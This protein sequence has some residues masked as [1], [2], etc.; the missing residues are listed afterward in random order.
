MSMTSSKDLAFIVSGG[1]T[2]TTYLGYVLGKFIPDAR[3]VHEP[4]LNDG[5]TLR[6]LNNLREFG[7]WHMVLGRYLK[8][9]GIRNLAQDYMSG[10]LG[11]DETVRSVRQQRDD[12]H[13]AQRKPFIIESYCQWYGLLD[14]LRVAYPQ[15]KVVAIIRDPRDW[16]TSWMNYKGH[17]DETDLVLRM[18]QQRINP[19]IVGDETWEPYWRHM[20]PFEK[21]CWEWVQVYNRIDAFIT[22]DV[23]C[24]LVRYEDLFSPQEFLSAVYFLCD[25][26]EHVYRYRVDF[27]KLSERRNASD[28]AM[29]HWADWSPEQ[30]QFIDQLCGPLMQKYGYGLEDTWQAKL[31]QPASGLFQTEQKAV[32]A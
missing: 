18:G 28:G 20:S 6:T 30:A 31:S 5:L 24:M 2:A 32:F 1:R 26:P 13:A 7:L 25:Q 3:S 11:F 22:K 4:D 27:A 15:A 10:E 14:P 9:T 29:A 17:H 12:W 16:V 21:L 19:S 23:N 8:R